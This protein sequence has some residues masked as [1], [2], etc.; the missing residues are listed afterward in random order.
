MIK[1][2]VNGRTLEI[3]VLVSFGQAE[4]TIVI[5]LGYGQG[6]DK[7]DELG[8]KPANQAHVGLV[9]VNRGFNAYPLR[10]P[11]RPISPPAPR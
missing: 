2:T 1:V 6:F 5:P 11:R 4:N 3:P 7:E 8:R 10:I 9:G